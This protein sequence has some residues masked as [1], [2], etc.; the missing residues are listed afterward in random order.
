M[1]PKVISE[2]AQ[3]N[4]FFLS[5]HFPVCYFEFLLSVQSLDCIFWDPKSFSKLSVAHVVFRGKNAECFSSAI[6][7]IKSKESQISA[8]QKW[9]L[10]FPSPVPFFPSRTCIA[11]LHC[12]LTLPAKPLIP[13]TGKQMFR[14][15]QIMCLYHAVFLVVYRLQIITQKITRSSSNASY[16]MKI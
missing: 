1:T 4:M 7:I 6:H 10:V 8:G 13:S 3:W 11:V 9:F 16:E 15:L 5:V 2:K 14:N 12:S